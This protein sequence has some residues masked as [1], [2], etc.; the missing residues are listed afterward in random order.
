MLATVVKYEPIVAQV[1][2]YA[3]LHSNGGHVITLIINNKGFQV[4][5]KEKF[6]QKFQVIHYL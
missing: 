3:I 2:T 6:S 5:R 4:E 1:H